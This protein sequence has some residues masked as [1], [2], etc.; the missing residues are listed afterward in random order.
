MNEPHAYTSTASDGECW[1]AADDVVTIN[2]LAEDR[3]GEERKIVDR[4]EIFYK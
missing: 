4:V 3:T 2:L 1:F